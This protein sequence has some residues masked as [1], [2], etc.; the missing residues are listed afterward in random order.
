MCGV[1][2]FAAYEIPESQMKMTTEELLDLSRAQM[3]L[4]GLFY[5]N[6]TATFSSLALETFY[7]T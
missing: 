6:P 3:M 5:S 2:F 4:R 7:Q 1:I